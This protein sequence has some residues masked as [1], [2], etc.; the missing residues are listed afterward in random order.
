[1]V[2]KAYETLSNNYLL[3]MLTLHLE[4]QSTDM[5]TS[6][7]LLTM[8]SYIDELIKCSSIPYLVWIWDLMTWFVN[9]QHSMHI[10]WWQV[11]HGQNTKN[12]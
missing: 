7:I 1:L 9:A 6:L 2:D 10:F 5:V 8:W 3:Y 11:S 4:P 12:A